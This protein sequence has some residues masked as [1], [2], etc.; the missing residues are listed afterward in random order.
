MRTSLRTCSRVAHGCKE[1]EN[2][3]QLL[4]V[5]QRDCPGG[6]PVAE[7]PRC[8][9]RGLSLIP[10]QGARIPKAATETWHSQINKNTKKKKVKQWS[11]DRPAQR[12]GG[13][14]QAGQPGWASR[15]ADV[16]GG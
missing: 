3:T 4:G 9:C 14:G 13:A 16:E 5:K 8:Q 12:R 15:G 11:S 7:T 6:G 2:S 10:G 1:A